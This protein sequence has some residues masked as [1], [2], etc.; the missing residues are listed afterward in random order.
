M[1]KPRYPWWPFAV[2]MV[3]QYPNN[4]SEDEITAVKKALENV[5]NRVDADDRIKMLNFVY[6]SGG[7][8]NKRKLKEWASYHVHCSVGTV[9]RWHREFIY[10]V[11][12]NYK[13]DGMLKDKL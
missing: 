10:D 7:Y 9:L 2:N 8:A 5:R 12:R 13:T 6:F 1:S 3:R 4:T 11:A